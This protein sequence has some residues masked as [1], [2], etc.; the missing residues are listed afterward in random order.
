MPQMTKMLE[1]WKQDWKYYTNVFKLII[2]SVIPKTYKASINST[3]SFFHSGYSEGTFR[4]YEISNRGLLLGS[5]VVPFTSASE[6]V[7]L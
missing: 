4:S 3:F 6:N 5:S 1:H 2:I 7:S